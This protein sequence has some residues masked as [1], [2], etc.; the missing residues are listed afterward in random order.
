MKDFQKLIE[1]SLEEVRRLG[2]RPGNIVAW[3]VNKRAKT[4]W[5]LCRQ[6]PDNTFEIQ[7]AQRLLTDER[8][9]RQSC[10]ETIIHEILHTCKD[11]MKHTGKWKHYAQVVNQVYGY[12]IKRVTTGSEKGV[13]DYDSSSSLPVKY[14]FTCGCCGATIYRKRESRFTKYYRQYRCTRCGAVAWEKKVV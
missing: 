6:N 11:C 7:I 10:K 3:S 2:I 14:I 1:E 4:R 8:I 12:N 9:S 5:G 13:E